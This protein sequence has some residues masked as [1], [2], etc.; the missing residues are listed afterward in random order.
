MLFLIQSQAREYCELHLQELSTK[1]AK[2]WQII[3]QQ[4]I[5]VIS[6]AE[7]SKRMHNRHKF[8]IKPKQHGS[9]KHILFPTPCS[10]QFPK[11]DDITNPQA[12]TQV[13]ESLE[14]FNILL[15]QIL[16]NS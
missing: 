3:A 14:V 9:T 10:N 1:Q 16:S 7:G 12:Q 4:A 8:Y 13:D 15:Q 11:N 5:T 2:A 6:E